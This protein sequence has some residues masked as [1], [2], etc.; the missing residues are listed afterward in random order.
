MVLP[1]AFIDQASP[2]D[3]YAAAGLQAGDIVAKVLDVLG[4][5]E[6]GSRRA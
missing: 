2:V 5:V 4:V 1:D 6:I 3:M